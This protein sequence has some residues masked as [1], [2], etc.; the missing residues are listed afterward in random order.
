MKSSAMEEF[1]NTILSEYGLLVLALLVGVI[2]QWRHIVKTET[3]LFEAFEK[4][5][6]VITKLVERLGEHDDNEKSK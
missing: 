6:T 4:N 1:F 2:T 5:T 3:R